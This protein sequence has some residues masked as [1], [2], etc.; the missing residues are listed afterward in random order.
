MP[1]KKAKKFSKG[2]IIIYKPSKN[3]VELKVRFEDETVWL[4]LN[5]IAELFGRDKSVISRHLRN[6]FEEGELFKDSVVAKIATTAADG[7]TYQVEFYSLDAIISVG[8]RVNSQRATQFR[9]WATKIL[10]NYLLQGYAVNEKRLL[11]ANNKFNQLQET[12][13]FLQKKAKAKILQG[14]EKEILNLLADYSKTLSLLEKY[15]KSKLKAE[16]GK[17]AK[18][19]LE[20]ENCLNVILELKKNLISKKEAGDIFGNEVSYKF[21]SI[22]KNLY[23]TFG[24][25]ELYKSIEA[26]AA[27]LLY[28]TIKD[29]PFTD[30][31]KRVGSFLFVYF[32]D[33]NNYLYR[34]SGE[35]KINDNALTALALLIAES[36]PKEKEQMIALTSQLIK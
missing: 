22:A 18:F 30:G 11:E 16:A 8:Y 19:V 36:N 7:K 31:N 14:Q 12:I 24:G 1:N 15:D 34:R 17:K 4:S 20:Y 32:L 35:K 9:I 33:R 26:K 6:I 25:K 29:H 21:E 2:E 10:K 13:S 5:Q 23:Q 27:H 28:L 3:E